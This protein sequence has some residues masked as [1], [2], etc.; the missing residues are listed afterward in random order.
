ME[1]KLKVIIDYLNKVETRCTYGVVAELI[2]VN[3]QS[4]GMH[5]GERRPEVSWVVN[6]STGDPT[7]YKESEK[8]P[9]L[10][11]TERIIKSAEVLRRNLGI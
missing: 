5:L 3:S 10:Y 2:G 1:G 6:A 8:H 11:R 7:D 4:V 9:N